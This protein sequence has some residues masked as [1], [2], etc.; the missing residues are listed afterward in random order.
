VNDFF[1]NYQDITQADQGWKLLWSA[2]RKADLDKFL[3]EHP[4]A[5]FSRAARKFMNDLT[6][7]KKERLSVYQSKTLAPEEKKTKLEALDGRIMQ[8]ARAANAFMDPE[9]AKTLKMPSRYVAAEGLRRPLIDPADYYRFVSE[10]TMDAYER[11]QKELPRLMMMPREERQARINSA[12]RQAR[13]DYQPVIKGTEAEELLK[14]Y[15][16]SALLAAPTR[17][18]RAG[19][20][21]LMGTRRVPPGLATGFRFKEGERK[22]ERQAR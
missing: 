4:E 18:E 3:A 16:L 21:H 17:A 15:R 10:T 12:L 5:M 2:G 11:L 20:Q 14:P 7:I 22:D 1:E 19:W 8:I 13:A 9:V 6:A